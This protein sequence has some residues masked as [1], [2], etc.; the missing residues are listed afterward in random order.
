[1]IFP[2]IRDYCD[3]VVTRDDTVRVKPH[4]DHIRAVLRILNEEPARSA[5]VGDHPMDVVVGKEV[6]ALSVGVLTGYSG[7][8]DLKSA[9]A[10]LILERVSDITACLL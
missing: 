10:D 3:A 2:D 1:V 9:G 7:I 6:G 4:P 5:M 8:A